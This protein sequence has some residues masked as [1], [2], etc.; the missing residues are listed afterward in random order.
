MGTYGSDHLERVTNEMAERLT[1]EIRLKIRTLL[2]I[3]EPEKIKALEAEI[4]LLKDQLPPDHFTLKS[5]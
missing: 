5:P 2:K 4:Q 1:Q 3:S